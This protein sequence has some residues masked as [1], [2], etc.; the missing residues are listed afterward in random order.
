M[1]WD[2]GVFHKQHVSV[3]AYMSLIYY[4]HY[5]NWFSLAEHG[6]VTAFL[7]S[8]HPQIWTKPVSSNQNNNK[9]VQ[10]ETLGDAIEIAFLF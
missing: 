8:F 7:F 3:C 5:Q 9:A 6:S 2:K 10:K 4:Y 1:W